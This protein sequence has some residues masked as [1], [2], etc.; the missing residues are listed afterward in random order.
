M[1]HADLISITNF[2]E[3]LI[4]ETDAV[5]S[6]NIT[7]NL[8]CL[9][10]TE[11]ILDTGRAIISGNDTTTDQRSEI[12]RRMDKIRSAI[13]DLIK[14]MD[15]QTVKSLLNQTGDKFKTLFIGN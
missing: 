2:A 5:N 1:T 6:R 7:A 12:N 15:P 11:E 14:Q 8:L 10:Y 4:L 9:I 13:T 3:K